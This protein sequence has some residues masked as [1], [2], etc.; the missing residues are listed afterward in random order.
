MRIIS[1]DDPEFEILFKAG[2]VA[3]GGRLQPAAGNPGPNRERWLN[4]SE[5]MMAIEEENERLS[6][7]ASSSPPDPRVTKSK[8][9]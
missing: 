5:I 4:E 2:K 6:R 3:V 8:D 1:G 7:D 9:R